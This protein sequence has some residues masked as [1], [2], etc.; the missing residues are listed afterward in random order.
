MNVRVADIQA[1][2]EPWQSRE[3]EFITEPKYK[4]GETRC[5]IRDPEWLHVRGLIAPSGHREMGRWRR[6]VEPERFFAIGD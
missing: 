4:Y 3:A 6:L 2:C 5:R 1:C